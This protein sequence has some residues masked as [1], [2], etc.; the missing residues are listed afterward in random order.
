MSV[1]DAGV[2][3]D[4]SGRGEL[5]LVCFENSHRLTGEESS[6]SISLRAG[7]VVQRLATYGPICV[8]NRRSDNGAGARWNFNSAR[9][10]RI[11]VPFS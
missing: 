6:I 8:Q 10:A 5:S 7:Q 4:W 2:E 1:H 3:T 11:P 9:S